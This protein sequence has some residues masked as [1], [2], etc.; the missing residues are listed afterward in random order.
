MYN[1]IRAFAVACALCLAMS[2]PACGAEEVL[3]AEGTP[4]V[5]GAPEATQAPEAGD[6]ADADANAQS[7]ADAEAKAAQQKERIRSAQR[8]L[9]DLG[10]LSGAA[11]GLYGP[12]TQS[13]LTRYQT[14]RG[15]EAT[16]ELDDA[17][18]NDLTQQAAQVGDTRS[19]QQRLISSCSMLSRCASLTGSS[20][21]SSSA[22]G[23]LAKTPLPLAL[24][25][26]RFCPWLPLLW[27][28]Q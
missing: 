27:W 23:S 24:S 11:D 20:I 2:G 28:W 7:E 19:V 10:Y 15:L 17:T 6:S 4:L 25:I 9:I 1:P 26:E 3:Q 18:M 22:S 14:D 21:R 16:G 8:M 5:A 12:M 13:A